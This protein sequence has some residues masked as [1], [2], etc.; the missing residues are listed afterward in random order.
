MSIN[1]LISIKNP[2]LDAKMHLGIDHDKDDPFFTRLAVMAEKEIG[3]YYQFERCR[4][5]LDITNCTAQLPNDSKRVELAILGDHGT[6]CGDLFAMAVNTL[7]NDVTNVNT[8]GIFLVVDI[9]G[10][11]DGTVSNFT[12][13]KYAIQNNKLIFDACYDGQK[14]T[15]QYLRFKVDCDGFMEIGEN[16]VNAIRWYIV[17]N[18]LFRQSQSNY[19]VRDKYQHA[20]QE[21]N[22]EC[23]HARATDN[24]ATFSQHRDMVRLFHNPMS[25]IGLWQG[26]NT[27]LGTN[28]S[29]W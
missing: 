29:I 1:K 23:A 27:T 17:Y 3:S 14:V 22:R 20:Y 21:W 6:A 18:Y 2:I 5:V 26:M 25:G 10:S 11:Q 12:Y 15:I 28:F 24:E 19:L 8:N 9:S 7:S 4:T 16:H 13:V